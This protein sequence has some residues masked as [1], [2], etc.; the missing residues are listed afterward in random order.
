MNKSLLL[1]IGLLFITLQ[2]CE[3]NLDLGNHDFPYVLTYDATDIDST[4]AT[5]RGEIFFDDNKEIMQSGFAW[6]FSN[7]PP[8]D[9]GVIRE[10]FT[11]ALD[12]SQITG[13]FESRISY[14][15]KDGVTVYARA[16]AKTKSFTV[17]GNVISFEG[18]GCLKHKI[19][20]ITPDQGSDLCKIVIK[21]SNISSNR[22]RVKLKIGDRYVYINSVIHNTIFATV[23]VFLTVGDHP[24][25]IQIDDF[26]VIADQQFTV[27]APVITSV[28]PLEGYYG[29]TITLTGQNFS[30]STYGTRVLIGSLPAK[31]IR[32]KEDTIIAQTPFWGPTGERN[33]E[34][35]ISGKLTTFGEPFT[36][37]P[38]PDAGDTE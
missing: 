16:F 36:V 30:S 15:I 13:P 24:V 31:L 5:M 34:V 27:L 22:D 8:P 20:S 2:G 25:S 21:G 3:N 37:F 11:Y 17:Y 28:S 4:G 7:K 1:F 23:P 6:Y 19:E 10:D 14:D 9:K 38:P 29:T 32:M 35:D 12:D 33:I 18:Q 26:T